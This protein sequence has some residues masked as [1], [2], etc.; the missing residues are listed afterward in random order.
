MGALPPLSLAAKLYLP[1]EC[2]FFAAPFFRHSSRVGVG[3]APG[4]FKVVI[5]TFVPTARLC[6]RAVQFFGAFI[7]ELQF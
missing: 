7:F 6:K 2:P 3:V 1:V 5:A 4:R